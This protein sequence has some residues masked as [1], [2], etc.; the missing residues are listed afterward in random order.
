MRSEALLGAA[1]VVGAV[2]VLLPLAD[3]GLA[4]HGPVLAFLLAALFA[5]ACA[6]AALRFAERHSSPAEIAL[7]AM[8]GALSAVARVPF[9]GIPSVQP[10]TFL[11]ISSGYV[12][13]AAP[14]FMVGAITAGVS[15]LFL[16]HGP[17]TLY[18]AFAWGL[19]GASGAWL[20]RLRPGVLGLA[21]FGALWGF[22]F[23]WLMDLWFWTAF[24]APLTLPSLAAVL[25]LSFAF[26]L[27]HAVGNV[28]FFLVFGPRV[29]AALALYA[30]RLVRQRAPP[31]DAAPSRSY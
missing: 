14:G 30:E 28:V 6:A 5:L 1:I 15:N 11:V 10:S 4:S 27:L 21:A 7:V 24:Y 25:A 22:L 31:A 16:G 3:P 12:F 19:A 8:L 29:I 17:W 26:D 18:Q 2:A 20:A 9:A 13:G 23:G